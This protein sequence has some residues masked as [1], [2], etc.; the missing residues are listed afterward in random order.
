MK[1]ELG[2]GNKP[3]KSR[4]EGW[5]YNDIRDLPGVDIV[6]PAYDLSDIKDD[7]VEEIY[8]RF[9]L[10]HLER[11]LINPAF[12]EWHRI[13]V[14]GGKI[15]VITLDMEELARQY[16]NGLIEPRWFEYVA[17][18]E[19]DY[20][21]N[22]HRSCFDAVK[23]GLHFHGAKFTR[24]NVHSA[25]QMKEGHEWKLPALVGEAWK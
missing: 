17:Y 24:I 6:A 10:E 9:M 13:L 4:D 21:E 18:G 16:V 8:S 23:L 19:Q 20:P 7:S 15:E 25:N 2:V 11:E 1:L 12:E 3:I 5:I 14:P 22:T